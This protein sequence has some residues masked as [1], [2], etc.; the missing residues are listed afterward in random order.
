VY[1]LRVITEPSVEPLSTADVKQHL[2]LASAVTAHDTRIAAM[3]S[4]ARKWCEDY[5]N[6]SFITTTWEL[7]MDRFPYQ[8]LAMFLPRPPLQS[9]TFVK[10]IDLQGT[11][12]TWAN[13]NYTVSTGREPGR[14]A[15]NYQVIFP[16]S[17]YQADAIKV[18][19]VAGYGDAA[20]NVPAGLKQA[21]LL[22]IGHWFEHRESVAQGVWNEVP[23]ATQSLL[24]SYKVGDEFTQYAFNWAS[25]NW[26]L[27]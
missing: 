20:V 24:E 13:T 16:Y 22:L 3:I 23:M 1:G 8:Q 26:W 19:Y 5:T 6:R 12:Q 21:M 7:S 9:V 10:Y 18:Q 2:N 17:R 25:T 11:E 4:A 14:I 27:F 15:C